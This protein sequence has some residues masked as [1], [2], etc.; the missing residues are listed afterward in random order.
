MTFFKLIFPRTDFLWHFYD[1]SPKQI[2]DKI[3]E[4]LNS[5]DKSVKTSVVRCASNARRYEQD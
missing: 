4:K 5:A 1:A 3:K 2:E